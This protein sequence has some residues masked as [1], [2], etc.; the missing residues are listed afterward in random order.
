MVDRD[1]LENR[2]ACKRTVGSNPTLSA[3]CIEKVPILS[4]F[5][6]LSDNL[7]PQNVPHSRRH[8][9]FASPASLTVAA[10]ALSRANPTAHRNREHGYRDRPLSLLVHALRSRDCNGY[11]RRAALWATCCSRLCVGQTAHT[12]YG[13]IKA[14]KKLIEEMTRC[15]CRTQTAR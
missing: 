7:I 13:R 2:C 4:I 14:A 9:A 5:Y 11:P 10:L 12:G 6:V 1:G 3:I 15:R 8:C